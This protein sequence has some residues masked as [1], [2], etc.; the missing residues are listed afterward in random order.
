MASE[1]WY[2]SY[3]AISQNGAGVPPPNAV[4][5]RHSLEGT[6]MATSN[7]T[8]NQQQ[9][10][11]YLVQA[12]TGPV[13]I[14]VAL[15][16]KGRVG[17]IQVGNHEQLSII[18]HFKIANKNLAHALEYAM[19]EYY[20]SKRIRG[21]WYQLT[22]VDI[23]HLKQVDAMHFA[24]MQTEEE[25][26]EEYAQLREETPQPI[27]GVALCRKYADLRRK[28]IVKEEIDQAL[29]KG[30]DY[31]TDSKTYDLVLGNSISQL[32]QEGI[33]NWLNY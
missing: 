14:G 31:R 4:S 16:L 11:L 21:E 7:N 19:H 1:A 10:Y 29:N 12:K 2:H 8:P 9:S 18:H 27:N 23:D 28:A 20:Q 33:F 6:D 26:L 5:N 17:E 24:E 15:D 22:L 13:K 32:K 30:L 25:V 3:N